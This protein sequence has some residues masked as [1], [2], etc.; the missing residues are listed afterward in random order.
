MECFSNEQFARDPRDV[1]GIL[2]NN[3]LYMRKFSSIVSR[4]SS[5]LFYFELER[6]NPKKDDWKKFLRFDLIIELKRNIIQD[7]FNKSSEKFF[8]LTIDEW[9]T[10]DF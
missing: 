6:K 1:L 8:H 10:K 2:I 9:N 3:R 5:I 7:F 4:M